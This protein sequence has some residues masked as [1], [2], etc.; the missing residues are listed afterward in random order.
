[1]S[2]LSEGTKTIHIRGMF[3]AHCEERIRGALLA[4]PGV[5]MADVSWEK[6][7]AIVRGDSSLWDDTL[8]Q[9]AIEDAGYEMA[10]TRE[11]HIQIISILVI[12]L[13]IWT[14][15]S[16]LGWTQIFNLFPQIETSLNIG[17]LFLAGLLTSVH[18][19]AMCGG[20]NLTQSVM[21]YSD[22]QRIIRSNALYHAGRVLSYALIGALAGGIGQALAPS[23]IFK[24]VIAILAGAAM[25]VMALNMLGVFRAL[26]KL[27]FRLSGR[28]HASLL[29][30]LKR[31]SSF[32]IGLLNG[33]MPCGPLQTM[34]LYALSTGNV[35]RG[36]LSMLTFSLGTVP[37]MFGFGL[38]SGKLNRKYSHAMLTVSALLIF[39][40]GLNMLG[41]GLALSGISL[42]RRSS[43]AVIQA[44]QNNG[45]QTLRTEIDYGSYPSV[46]VKAGV[47]L[48]WIIIVPEG[49]LNGC[50]CEILIPAHQIDLVLQEG[51]NHVSF[52]PDQPGTIP[53]S[54]WMGMIRGTIEVTD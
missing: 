13:A 28:P 12:L 7:T 10:V 2:Q 44:M 38:I 41:N 6:E 32:V 42:P 24:G 47:P 53:Y 46:R 26:K 51:E 21:A 9:K 25:L 31:G 20:I 30:R 54:C 23:G 48:D 40:M 16:H 8:F 11:S 45:L 34:Q 35:L 29:G 3:C 22:K 43:S 33:L 36:A 4:L 18:C 39:L 1:M 27:S 50:N 15:A 14:I 52:V 5:E 49:K 19:L 37:L 17:A